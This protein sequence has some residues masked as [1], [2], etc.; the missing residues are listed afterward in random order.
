MKF[1]ILE[2]LK[3]LK[4][5]LVDLSYDLH[6]ENKTDGEV[7]EIHEELNAINYTINELESLILEICN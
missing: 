4:A 2:R 3:T 6:D 1:K 5:K 7:I